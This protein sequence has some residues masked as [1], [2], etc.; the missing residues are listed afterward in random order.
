MSLRELIIYAIRP[1]CQLRNSRVA[2]SR[3]SMAPCV[4]QVGLLILKVLL[5]GHVLNSGI[6][7]AWLH[8]EESAHFP[9]QR[10]RVRET[11]ILLW[12]EIQ[13]FLPVAL[14]QTP[15]IPVH[16]PQRRGA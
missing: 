3:W 8:L 1:W 15:V 7:H 16:G 10:H 12:K 14:S 11:V 4:L 13:L 9:G 2:L 5:S 6:R